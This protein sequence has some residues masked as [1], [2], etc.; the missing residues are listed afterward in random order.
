MPAR[1]NHWLVKSEPDKYSWE[2]LVKDGWTYWDGVRNYEAR[3]NLRAMGVGDRLL[4]YHSNKGTAV[5]G[6]A[7]VTREQYQDPTTED[8]RWCVVDVKPVVALERPVTL[9]AIKADS[10]LNEMVVARR[11]RLSVSPV[12]PAEFRRVLELGGLVPPSEDD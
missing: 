4:Y 10:R 7:E 3:N 2:D 6:V 5:V 1:P 9:A 8:E 11:S 12:T